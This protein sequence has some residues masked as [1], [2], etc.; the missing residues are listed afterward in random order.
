M[1]FKI[2]HLPLETTVI[3]KILNLTHLMV[4]DGGENPSWK[5]FGYEAKTSATIGVFVKNDRI[6]SCCSFLTILTIEAYY[7][8]RCVATYYE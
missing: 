6:L 7:W 2:F 1:V 8:H 4:A 3:L 5:Y